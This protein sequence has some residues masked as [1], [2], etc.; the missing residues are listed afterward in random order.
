MATS[1]SWTRDRVFMSHR[2]RRIWYSRSED[3]D[4]LYMVARGDG[5]DQYF[6]DWEDAMNWIDDHWD[7]NGKQIKEVK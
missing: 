6:T 2:R 3:G 1:S 7:M 5:T 4:V